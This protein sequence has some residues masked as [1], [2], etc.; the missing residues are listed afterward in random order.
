MHSRKRRKLDPKGY[1]VSNKKKAREEDTYYVPGMD[2]ESEWEDKCVK[3]ELFNEENSD[4]YKGLETVD[5]AGEGSE[6]SITEN[7]NDGKS[8]GCV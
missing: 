1:G 4:S 7:I 2:N 6:V 5:G 8:F 3:V